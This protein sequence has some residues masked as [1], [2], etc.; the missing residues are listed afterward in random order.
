MIVLLEIQNQWQYL[1]ARFPAP[2]RTR[3][4]LMH[5]N[6]HDLFGYNL[7]EFCV[8]PERTYALMDKYRCDLLAAPFTE[9]GIVFFSFE[10]LKR[11]Y[12]PR[13]TDADLPKDTQKKYGFH[14]VPLCSYLETNMNLKCTSMQGRLVFAEEKP[15][16]TRMKNLFYD[17]YARDKK[18]GD[19]YHVFWCENLNRM[20]P[21]RLYVPTWYN[22]NAPLRL[23]VLMHGGGGNSDELFDAS[24]NRLQKFAEKERYL[25]LAVDCGVKNSTYGCL[26]LPKGADVPGIDDTCPDNP[27]HLSPETIQ[28]RKYSEKAV[29]EVIALVES[30]YAID[31]EHRYLFGN[32]MGG[33]GAFHFPLNHRNFFRAV[34]PAG[35]APDPR[36]FHFDEL[37]DLPILIIA[38]TEDYHGYD[39]IYEVYEYCRSLGLNVNFLPVAGGRHEDCWADVLP[40]IFAFCRKNS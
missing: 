38:G 3:R 35:A 36:F 9:D 11:I 16:E 30:R 34:I 15:V 25:L 26:S 18:L 2:H 1:P 13:L 37:H 14:Y 21:Y 40:E 7:K 5:P 32:S 10:D 4:S 39:H 17:L 33:M 31:T 20:L 24:Q 8:Y 28:A 19:L 27:L 6:K 22:D 12:S 29:A 23:M